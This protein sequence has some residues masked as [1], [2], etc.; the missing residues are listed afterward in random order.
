MNNETIGVAGAFARAPVPMVAT[1]PGEKYFSA[2]LDRL[3]AV[4]Y[5]PCTG[6]IATV[7]L[8]DMPPPESAAHLVGARQR[9][10]ALEQHPLC[11]ETCC[12]VPAAVWQWQTSD[13]DDLTV[14]VGRCDE[15]RIDGDVVDPG[16]IGVSFKVGSIP[17]AL[18][19]RR[20]ADRE[21]SPP[22]WCAC[23]TVTDIGPD[24]GLR[25]Y[26]TELWDWSTMAKQPDGSWHVNC[27]RCEAPWTYLRGQYPP[28]AFLLHIGAPPVDTC[29]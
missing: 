15:H 11:T 6:A 29:E 17:L 10:L 9:V 19:Q 7:E 25:L 18:Y 8:S 14:L 16:Q 27:R 26:M 22:L 2:F 12:T 21:P 5:T 1:A 24:R 23:D 3:D 20:T 28:S 13:Y 4:R